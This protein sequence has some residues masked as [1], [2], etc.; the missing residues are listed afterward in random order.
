VVL[1]VT[2]NGRSL[3][4]GRR[5]MIDTAAPASGAHGQG[6]WC[7][8]RGGTAGLVGWKCV[9]AGTPGTWEP[10]YSGYG[11]G[12]VGYASGA[13]GAVIQATSKSTAVTLNKLSGQITMNAEELA[14]GAA[15]S[16]TVENSQVAATDTIK[17][18]LASGN[19]AP[20]TYNYQV[21]GVTPGSFVI[22]IRNISE[23]A[24]GEALTFNF[25]ILKGANS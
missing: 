10:I 12:P 24:L 14:A 2:D 8:Y 5:V 1:V 6:E 17:L 20:G 25:S 16:F 3:A 15:V 4:N 19:G 13:G 7:L 11:S 18:A 9:A 22:C 21:D 23:A